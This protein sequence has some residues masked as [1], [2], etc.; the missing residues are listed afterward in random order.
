MPFSWQLLSLRLI[1][2]LNTVFLR[3]EPHAD[4]QINNR[5]DLTAPTPKYRLEVIKAV[6]IFFV[7]DYLNFVALWFHP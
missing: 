4:A 1:T 3:T 5:R 7:T 6:A 2:L